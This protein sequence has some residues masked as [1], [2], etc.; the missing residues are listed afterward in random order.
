MK[1]IHDTFFGHVT[2]RDHFIAKSFIDNCDICILNMCDQNIINL[3]VF[4]ACCIQVH[5]D[6]IKLSVFLL[7]TFGPDHPPYSDTH[8]TVRSWACICVH[9]CFDHQRP[10]IT[11]VLHSKKYFVLVSVCEQN[12][13]GVLRFQQQQPRNIQNKKK[14]RNPN[15]PSP[16]QHVKETQKP[17][18]FI[19]MNQHARITEQQ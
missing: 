13:Q 6:T 3:V 1:K 14:I 10:Y 5:V 17:E 2:A 19:I 4:C 7:K 16:Q 8:Q 9:V 18:G 15:P 11:L 12:E